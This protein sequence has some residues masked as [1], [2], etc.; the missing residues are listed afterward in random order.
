MGWG[1]MAGEED[2]TVSSLERCMR[3][4]GVEQVRKTVGS[5]SGE[6]GSPRVQK[7]S[8]LNVRSIMGLLRKHM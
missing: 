6:L 7:S 1:A 4:T 8:R 2:S 3:H 5:M